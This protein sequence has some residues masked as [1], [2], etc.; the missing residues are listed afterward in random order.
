MVTTTRLS[1]PDRRH[2]C[3]SCTCLLC[4]SL[5]CCFAVSV[6]PDVAV[7]VVSD[8]LLSCGTCFIV[9]GSPSVD[10]FDVV[11][12]VVVVVVVAVVVVAVVV[13]VVVI[14]GCTAAV[15]CGSISTGKVKI[16]FSI[17]GVK[18]N[19]FN[20]GMDCLETSKFKLMIYKHQITFIST[21]EKDTFPHPPIRSAIAPITNPKQLSTTSTDLSKWVIKIEKGK[22]QEVR[23][24]G[25]HVCWLSIVSE[26]NYRPANR[27]YYLLS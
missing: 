18:L 23:Y 6:V 7:V 8:S 26:L 9:G 22:E 1:T 27:I 17:S 21:R 15:S 4:L 11:D 16:E 19:G 12:V 24:L 25:V 13:A 10:A 14:V 2:S 20:A 5:A 3:A